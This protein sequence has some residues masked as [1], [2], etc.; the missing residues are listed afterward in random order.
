MA[1]VA[2]VEMNEELRGAHGLYLVAP[3]APAEIAGS[4]AD[5]GRVRGLGR[6]RRVKALGRHRLSGSGPVT[7]ISHPPIQA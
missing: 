2:R 7:W 4:G 1:A 6:R 3:R 5:I